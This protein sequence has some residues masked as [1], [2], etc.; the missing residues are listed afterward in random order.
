MS[1]R[2]WASSTGGRAGV[3]NS[4]CRATAK[5]RRRTPCRRAVPIRSTTSCATTGT[6][7][8]Q[9]RR[10]DARRP[11]PRRG[12]L[13]LDP[14][15]GEGAARNGR[16]RQPLRPRQRGGGDRGF[17]EER[18]RCG[19]QRGAPHPRTFPEAG[20]FARSGASQR[21]DAVDCRSAQCPR[22][23]ADGDLAAGCADAVRQA[24]SGCLRNR[25]TG[26]ARLRRDR[27]R[28]AVS[29]RLSVH[30]RP[31]PSARL[32]PGGT[33]MTRDFVG[34][35]AMPPHASWPDGA[36]IAVNFVINFEE[37]SELSYP[38]GDGVSETGLIEAA[39]TDAGMG[40]DLA[41]ESMFEYGSRVGWWRLHRIFTR[42]GL[43][44]T[45]FACAR[46]LAANPEA[47]AAIGEGDWDI[48]GHGYRWIKHYELDEAE[49]RRQIAA[50]V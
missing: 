9:R 18:A 11:A 50:A 24:V 14:V 4:G 36:R 34:Y 39:S 27:C 8:P 20:L 45:L 13:R 2:G 32:V 6:P 44:V 22:R 29:A 37:G 17:G 12:F 46:A 21:L 42:A 43:P 35:G 5:A 31:N 48:C 7:N 38:A 15:P 28:G 16:R 33:E 19:A 3:P 10:R 41:A 1:R 49:E 30:S 25:G 26:A 23:Q 47:A 40:R